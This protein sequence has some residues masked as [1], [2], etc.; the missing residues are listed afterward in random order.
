[1]EKLLDID[2]V[3]EM[4]GVTKATIYAW[5]SQNK[6][7]HVKL[8]RKLLKF[9][10]DEIKAWIVAKSISTDTCRPPE[11]F[12][13]PET[14]ISDHEDFIERIISNAKQEVLN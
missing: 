2:D 9:R 11:Q 12:R 14:F 4:L 5:T 7:P 13:R 8:S 10:G 1:M 6:I 3:S